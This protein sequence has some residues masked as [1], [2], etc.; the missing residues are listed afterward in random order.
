MNIDKKALLQLYGKEKK[1]VREIGLIVGK[2]PKQI[3]V[4]LKKFGIKARPFSTKGLRTWLGRKHTE[5]TKQKIRK[6]HLGKKL[7]A[8]HRAKV[9][10]T[11]RYGLKGKDNPAWKGGKSLKPAEMRKGA[12][13][14][15]YRMIKK[16]DHPF[17]EK[18]GYVLEHRLVMEKHLGRYLQK[19]EFVH[20]I[21]GIK[22][23]NRIENLELMNT[24][25]HNGR[26]KCPYC[27][28]EFLIH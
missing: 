8:E 25:R 19:G 10:K 16:T 4:Y 24:I 2:S 12:P 27:H 28:K 23:D 17:A 18:N 13:K 14:Q 15:W 6:Q 11:L 20:H 5:A 21:N 9:I 1:S 26:T 7:S 22:D 3:S